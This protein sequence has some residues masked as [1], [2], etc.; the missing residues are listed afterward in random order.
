MQKFKKKTDEVKS[1]EKITMLTHPKSK[2]QI[3]QKKLETA[4]PQENSPPKIQSVGKRLLSVKLVSES[5]QDIRERQLKEMR[6]K[7]IKR[8]QNAQPFV[9]N[10]AKEKSLRTPSPQ[11]QLHVVW[12]P[13]EISGK[14]L[15]H[16]LHS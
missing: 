8:K 2:C 7:S 1:N 5:P 11:Q 15:Q 3:F 13:Q 12:T 16:S 10:T 6:R 9:E 14:L 4:Q